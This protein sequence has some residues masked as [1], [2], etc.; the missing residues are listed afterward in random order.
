ML[1]LLGHSTWSQLPTVV[2]TG[3]SNDCSRKGNSDNSIG[4]VVTEQMAA[5]S[6]V[7]KGSNSDSSSVS[8]SYDGC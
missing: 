5:T 3:S 7:R 8:S 4:G 6:S 1:N 2:T